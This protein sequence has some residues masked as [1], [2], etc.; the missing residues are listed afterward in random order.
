MTGPAPKPP[1]VTEI[2]ELIDVPAY[3][4]AFVTMALGAVAGAVIIFVLLARI[5]KER[6][7]N[8]NA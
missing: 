6:E 7:A 2:V 5:A 1:T 8:E 3:G 4:I